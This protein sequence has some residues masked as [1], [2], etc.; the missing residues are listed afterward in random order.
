[1]QGALRKQPIISGA[2]LK[3]GRDESRGYFNIERRLPCAW[4]VP[5]R[6]RSTGTIESRRDIRKLFFGS[7]IGW[8]VS[9][10]FDGSRSLGRYVE[11]NSR[12]RR[13]LIT[14]IDEG[15]PL[16]CIVQDPD[17]SALDKEFLRSLDV[18]AVDDPD[19]FTLINSTSL[20]MEV[21]GFNF[22]Y[23]WIA[24]GTWPAAIICYSLNQTSRNGMINSM[25]EAFRR[26]PGIVQ[27]F[28][29]VAGYS[30]Y[31]R[32]DTGHPANPSESAAIWTRD[33]GKTSRLVRSPPDEA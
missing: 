10:R 30:L 28:E 3:N 20:V 21:G 29:E 25:V 16:P 9:A 11:F 12:P 18:T 15:T 8:T 4:N 1:M 26:E 14:P 13:P 2:D 31:F 5:W 23:E 33:G 27:N 24:Q 17:F 7:K 32:E 22:L 19:A 6:V